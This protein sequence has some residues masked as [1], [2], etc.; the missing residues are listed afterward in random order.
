MASSVL[1]FDV[2]AR[3]DNMQLLAQVVVEGF[4]LG[5]HRSPFRGF[6]VE[7]AEYR[8]YSPGDDVKHV[9]WKVFAKTD[10]YYL[11]QFEEETN[12]ACYLIVDA[13]GSMGY[14][15]QESGPTKLQYAKCLAACLAYFMIHQRDATG[16]LLFDKAV[17]TIIPPRGSQ[18]H[19]KHV[20]SALDA[21]KPGGETDIARPLHEL[22]AGLKRRGLVILIS[23]LIDD[24]EAVLSALQHFR[25]LG[26]DVI[27]FH[28]L[29]S[30]ELTFPFDSLTE[31]TDLETGARAL[32]TPEG[33][34]GVY[35][36]HMRRFL[37]A[38]EKGCAAVR[39]D[40]RLFDT[41][42]PLDLALSEYLYRR[43]R[44]M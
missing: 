6:S 32:I 18:T 22:A 39:A 27:V 30:A 35:M 4:I 36:E 34:R 10:R 9:D 8:Q 23:D 42:R 2:L 12:L 44:L 43:S 16:L 28:V 5:L 31:F 21:V 20:L 41:T 25:F 1:D 11:K 26:H 13:S 17:R 29:D 19:L 14:G 3:C 24:P 7:F 37:T 15:S 40:Y 33:M 38:Y